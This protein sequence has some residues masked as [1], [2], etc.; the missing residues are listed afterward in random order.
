MKILLDTHILLWTMLDRPLLS[1]K[2]R[3]IISQNN[4]SCYY[5]L[6]SIWE[7][8]I[9]HRLHPENLLSSGEDVMELCRETNIHSLSLNHEHIIAFES[10]RRREDAPQHKDPFDQIL[11]S[12]AK[13]ENMVFLTH[14][15]TLQY[16]DDVDVRIV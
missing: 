13:A 3:D 6:V 10:L 1:T 8:A 2:A 5:S 11:I 15:R 12:Q 9:K 7:I 16:Y 4:D 14:D